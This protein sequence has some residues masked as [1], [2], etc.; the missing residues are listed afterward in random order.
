M[1]KLSYLIPAACL[2]TAPA[3][4]AHD[5]M[6]PEETTVLDPQQTD[7]MTSDM[8]EG[9]MQKSGVQ[10]ADP[11]YDEMQAPTEAPPPAPVLGPDEQA[12]YDSWPDQRKADFAALAPATQSYFWSLG[13]DR[14]EMFW[15]IT[16][17]DR[18]ALAGMNAEEQDAAWQQVE[19]MITEAR[20][21][22]SSEPMNDTPEQAE[23]PDGR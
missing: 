21:A 1:R 5:T 18:E 11:Q 17:R 12:V 14:Q 4:I 6:S 23:G 7:A 8:Q 2:M 16:P 15:A 3:A 9:D 22:A 13:A 19:Q 20:A 10:D